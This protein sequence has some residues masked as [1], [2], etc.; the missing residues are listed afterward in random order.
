MGH[1][2]IIAAKRQLACLACAALPATASAAA[3]VLFDIGGL[4]QYALGFLVLLLVAPAFI[5]FIPKRRKWAWWGA[6]VLATAAYVGVPIYGAHKQWQEIQAANTAAYKRM[7]EDEQRRLT[8]FRRF[9]SERRATI[10]KVLKLDHPVM[11]E[12]R[13]GP[14]FHGSIYE[15][16]LQAMQRLFQNDACDS[17]VIAWEASGK[18]ENRDASAETGYRRIATCGRQLAPEIIEKPSAPYVL[19]LGDLGLSEPWVDRAA[20][21]TRFSSSSARLLDKATGEVLAEDTL[22]FISKGRL[23]DACPVP[24]EQIRAL[25]RGVF[26]RTATPE[27][28]R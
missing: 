1:S 6:W 9:C 25:I 10:H 5:I 14:R 17:E 8:A 13:L 2:R 18:L 26:A 20:N 3:P 15:V 21:G 4:A 28:G 19:S 7:L 24:Q 12:V 16:N 23:D 22:Y 27:A 11:V